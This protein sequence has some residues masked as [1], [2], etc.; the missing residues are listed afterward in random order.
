M[1]GDSALGT[2]GSSSSVP[3]S[4]FSSLECLDVIDL[5]I[6]ADSERSLIEGE[7]P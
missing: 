5:R 7:A 1:T 4:S 6:L 3:M 2:E